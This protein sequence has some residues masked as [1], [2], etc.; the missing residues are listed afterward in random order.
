MTI[1]L[2]KTVLRLISERA[3]IADAEVRV[4]RRAEQNFEE[5]EPEQGAPQAPTLKPESPK[6]HPSPLKLALKPETAKLTAH[7]CMSLNPQPSTPRVPCG[8][9]RLATPWSTFVHD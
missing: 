3:L 9:T 4:G 2:R 8:Y 7:A 6:P 1:G 5:R